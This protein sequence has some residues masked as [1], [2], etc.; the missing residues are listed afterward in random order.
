MLN[1]IV[2]TNSVI[3]RYALLYPSFKQSFIVIVRCNMKFLGDKVIKDFK[4][5]R[6]WV[7]K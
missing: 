2:V 1:F 4:V 7:I 5:V 3:C 6:E